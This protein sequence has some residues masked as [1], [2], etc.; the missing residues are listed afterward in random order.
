MKS[1]LKRALQ[2]TP[3]RV[4]RFGSGHRFQAIED[5]MSNLAHR[6]YQP[7][8]VIDSG[9]HMGEFSRLVRRIWPGTFLHMIE[10]QLSCRP[11]LDEIACAGGSVVHATAIGDSVGVLHLAA[12]PDNPSTGAHVLSGL[13]ENSAA[14]AA[15]VIEVPVTT[16]DALFSDPRHIG[17]PCLLK[18]DLQGYELH[19]LRGARNVLNAVDVV[20]TE[21][22]FFAQAY[23]PSIAALVSFLDAHGF[24]LHDIAALTGRRR[25]NR[26]HQGDFLFVKRDSALAS[27]TGWS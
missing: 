8:C 21:V 9:A 27:D 12:N 2:H 20:L 16:L 3:Y 4:V 6:G 19:A 1:L 17:N 24:D 25:D 7:S 22:S 23:E 11:A 10:P 13:Q 14:S 5:V 18:L 15:A 26:A